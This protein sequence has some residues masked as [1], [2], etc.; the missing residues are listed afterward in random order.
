MANEVDDIA[1]ISRALMS[2]KPEIVGITA[3]QWNNG[4]S[5]MLNTVEESC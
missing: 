1:A 3:A 2:N 5:R 4:Y